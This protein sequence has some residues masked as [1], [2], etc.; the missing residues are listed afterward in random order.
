M[1]E[2]QGL[3]VEWP[4]TCDTETGQVAIPFFFR[5]ECVVGSDDNDGATAPGVTGDTDHRRG[6]AAQRLRPD[7]RPRP[8]GARHRRLGRR[9][10]RDLLRAGRGVPAV[11]RDLRAHRR[12][13]VR[14]GIG[15]DAR[16]RGGAGRR[17]P[18][19]RVRA[20]RGVG[21]PAARLD[22]DRGAACPR[23]SCA[24]RARASSDTEPT[25]FGILPSQSQIQAHVVSYVARKLGGRHGRVRRGGQPRARSASSACCRWRRATPTSAGS[26]GTSRRS[27]KR[28]STSPRPGR[29]R[30][31]LPGPRSSP[32]ASSPG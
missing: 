17:H 20:V 4:D 1:A 28:A 13:R 15:H 7:L 3:D 31:T 25:A 2:Q 8:P 26:S 14:P 6:V 10:P 24:C 19:G 11:L 32:P 22:V 27:P 18:G 9:D 23:A 5:P 12:A 21:R 29:S 30:S 16:P